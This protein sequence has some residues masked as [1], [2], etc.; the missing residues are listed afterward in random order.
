[1]LTTHMLSAMLNPTYVA[2]AVDPACALFGIDATAPLPDGGAEV[3]YV[4]MLVLLAAFAEKERF[5]YVDVLL[6]RVLLRML[7][8]GAAAA[9]AAGTAA[10]TAQSAESETESETVRI[11]K[12][13]RWHPV[14]HVD[15]RM[16]AT[17]INLGYS[18]RKVSEMMLVDEAVIRRVIKVMKVLGIYFPCAADTAALAVAVAA[19]TGALAVAAD[20]AAV[21]VAADTAAVA[22]AGTAAVAVA[23]D[24]AALA[25][26]GTAAVAVSLPEYQQHVLRAVDTVRGCVL[27]NMD[28][29][30]VF[31]YKGAFYPLIPRARGKAKEDACIRRQ[32]LIEHRGPA[33]VAAVVAWVE[34]WQRGGGEL[35]E[36]ARLLLDWSARASAVPVPVP[37][38]AAFVSAPAAPPA[39]RKHDAAYSG[40][41]KNVRAGS[42]DDPCE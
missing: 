33:A 28:R 22:A 24:T 6:Q 42:D 31:F 11:L 10:A 16:A 38:P 17:L 37:V 32:L 20:T 34:S 25:A 23:A 26:A 27:R 8:A 5:A 13:R 41:R 40:H 15:G 4:F 18:V 12:G 19:D 36:N 14:K 2:R 1:M 39:K 9:T 3:V 21:A 35:T 29:N 30:I 7:P